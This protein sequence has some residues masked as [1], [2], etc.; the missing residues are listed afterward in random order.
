VIFFPSYTT[1]LREE[2]NSRKRIR[3]SEEKA[4]RSRQ[5]AI[6]TY[7]IML[8]EEGTVRACEGLMF[9]QS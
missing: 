6:T 2:L 9:H 7:L 1:S 8:Q 5:L 3:T 4:G